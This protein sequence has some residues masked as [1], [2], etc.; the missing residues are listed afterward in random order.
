MKG[1]KE[2]KLRNKERKKQRKNKEERKKN[3]REE[4]IKFKGEMIF[5]KQKRHLIRFDI[6]W[7]FNGTLTFVG[8]LMLKW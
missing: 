2:S 3:K 7:L 1:K 4:M 6:I 8:Y 5:Y